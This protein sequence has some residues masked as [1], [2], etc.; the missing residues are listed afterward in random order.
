MNA[1]DAIYWCEQ[2]E[3]NVVMA[4]PERSKMVLALRAMQQCKKALAK[5]IPQ[6][7]YE[8]YLNIETDAKVLCCPACHYQD[9]C[10]LEDVYDQKYKFCPMCGQALDWGK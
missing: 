7:P 5:Q 6:K 4:A 3:N 10:D 8:S 2:F 9:G 1:K